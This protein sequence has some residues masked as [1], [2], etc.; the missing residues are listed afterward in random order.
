MGVSMKRKVLFLNP[1]G[2][3]IYIRDYYC[4]K[5]SKAYYLPQPVDLLMQTGY[6]AERGYD[7]AVIDAIVDKLSVEET[8]NQVI[9]LAPELIIT[10]CGAVSF[11]EDDAFFTKVKSLLPSVRILSSG[12]LFLE[13]PA[14]FLKQH[15]WLDG[16]IT[17]WFGDGSL[18][19]FEKNV[20]QVTGMVFRENGSIKSA[21]K[22]ERARFVSMPRPRHE[23]FHGR[24]YRYAFMTHQP[25][26][27]VL[28]NYACPYPCTF[29]IMST[30]GFV[31]RWPEEVIEELRF[32]KKLGTRYI[33]FSDQTFYVLKEPTD[34]ILDFMIKEDLGMA[35]CCFS[36]VDRLDEV[37]LIK[38]KKAGCN[39][40]MFGVEWAEDDLLKNYRKDYSTRQIRETFAI[41]KRVGLKRM[42]TFLIGVPGQS[43]ASIRRT[44]EFA[45]ELDADYASFNV[46]VPRARTSFR[47]EAIE[48]G[49]IQP[50]DKIMDQSGSFI[51]MGTGILTPDQ[52]YALK[53]EAYRE[54][55]FRPG[56]LLKR[57]FKI[58]TYQELKTHFR[59]GYYVLK[60][61][62][63]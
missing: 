9:Q 16:V 31:S 55:Y 25:M 46:A 43:E 37:K 13:D 59:E 18:Q 11:S 62:L 29:C 6:F 3:D 34:E 42:G 24:A 10:Q 41:A 8:I 17:N 45:V 50:D 61:L 2:K 54:F 36:R 57:V 63:R 60:G 38:M 15:A 19:Y 35:W 5:V 32:L 51:A 48:R 44:V 14:Y 33:Y 22:V 26:A 58:Q 47:D 39:V 23:Y 30:L 40:V 52:I 56:Y 1:P 20:D 27:T 21:E 53:Q 12:D 28:T 4:S 7:T 49:L